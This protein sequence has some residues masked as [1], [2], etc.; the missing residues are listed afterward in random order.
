MLELELDL[1]IN[2]K[3]LK[4]HLFGYKCGEEIT[5]E[6]HKQALDSFLRVVSNRA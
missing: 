6:G 4:Y 3:G 1:F 2:L 5:D